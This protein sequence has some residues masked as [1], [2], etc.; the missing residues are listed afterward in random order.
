M[1]R[2]RFKRSGSIQTSLI[3]CAW[4]GYKVNFLDTPGYDD[5]LGEVVSALRV[6]EGATILVAA[7]SGVDVGTE[8]SWNMCQELNLPRLVL[9][10][11][12]DRGKRQLCPLC[13]GHSGHLRPALRPVSVAHRRRP[14]LPGRGEHSPAAG[15][16]A[17]GGSRRACRGTRK[18]GGSR[19][20]GR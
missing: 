6:V 14:G 20:R 11:K 16:G 9:V 13:G 10:N 5:F 2:R 8:R 1:S 18:V 15:G 7:P 17:S 12:M 19:S 4:D 3:A